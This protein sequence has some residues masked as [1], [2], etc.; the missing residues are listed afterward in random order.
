MKLKIINFNFIIYVIYQ[1]NGKNR[2]MLI[3]VN[4]HYLFTNNE[5]NNKHNIIF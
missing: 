2:L 5:F 1:I 3:I 4:G